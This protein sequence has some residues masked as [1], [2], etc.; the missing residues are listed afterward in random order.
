MN[1]RLRAICDLSVSA[2]REYVG[3]HEYDGRIEDLSPAGVRAAL[4]RLGGSPEG[5]GEPQGGAPVNREEDR[6][7]EAHLAAFERLVR[8]ELGELELHRSNP[9]YHIAALD[10]SCYDREYA[11]PAERAEARRRH[12]AAWPE[13]V[14]A[15]V[16]ALD[17]VAAP[18]AEALLSAA[19]GLTADLEPGDPVV[20][21]ALAAH[22]RL[23]AH[24]E[25]AAADGHR[26]TA[27]GRGPLERLLG[28]GEA[29]EVDLGRLEERAD[30]ERD[31]LRAMLDEA[32]GRLSPG[33]PTG[34]VVAALLGDHPDAGGVLAEAQAMTAESIAFTI[35]RD[36]VPG[37][38]GEC[39]VAPAPPSR[40]W[41]LAMMSWAAPYEADAPSRYYISPPEPGWPAA[42]QDDWLK[43]FSRT[44]LPAITVH[45]VA[46]GHFAHGRRLRRL[47]SDV[48]RTL[49]SMSFVEG[50]AHYGEE[51]CVEE[52]FR[53]DDPRFAAG[54]AL[55]ALQR[56][57]RLA[58]SI[59]THAGTMTVADGA[60]RFE[61]DAFA[62]GPAARAE[63][64]RA[65]FDP[66]YGRYTWGKLE[67]LRLRDEARGR[68]GAGFTPARFHDALLRLGSPPLGL[69]PA[70]LRG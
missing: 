29:L 19:R 14:D 34:Q 46:P 9:L 38:D 37:L 1:Q 57:T 62:Y 13:A 11:P 5:S 27:L 41:A 7:D 20:E 68:W 21:R 56:V 42:E 15:A 60:A 16:T 12:L 58:V 22:E 64:A 39:L 63:A 65:T 55:E 32:C 26:D 28:T 61:A 45:E 66:T 2:V 50:W 23:V 43:V 33:R 35:E 4:A 3:R 8:L 48:R 31:R 40:R 10:V 36:L 54:V 25:A 53:G 44:T 67:I 70:A 52:G 30:A 59:G 6:H 51:V 47:T 24:L 69:L 18:V 17:R 49:H